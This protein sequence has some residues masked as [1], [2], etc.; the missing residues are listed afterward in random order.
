M[1]AHT[2]KRARE[3]MS[4]NPIGRGSWPMRR[5]RPQ[6]RQHAR[7]PLSIGVREQSG[8][9]AHTRTR[10]ERKLRARVARWAQSIGRL[11]PSASPLP[12]PS[13]ASSS[14]SSFS[15]GWVQTCGCAI[16]RAVIPPK[17][18]PGTHRAASCVEASVQIKTC[19][20]RLHDESYS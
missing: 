1:P 12:T 14:S 3:V 10:G 20:S 13:S 11:P 16:L 17:G 19:P 5:Q 8:G 4:S 6:H 15:S 18:R 7:A 2:C 9:H